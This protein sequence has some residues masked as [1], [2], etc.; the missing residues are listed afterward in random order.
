MSDKAFEL[1]TYYTMRELAELSGIEARK[2]RRVLEG[3]GVPLKRS[4]IGGKRAHVV[5]FLS[6][7]KARLPEFWDSCIEKRVLDDEDGS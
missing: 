6:D 7:L 5:V 4:G 3:N 1:K 2:V